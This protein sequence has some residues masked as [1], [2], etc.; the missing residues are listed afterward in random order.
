M[1][2]PQY[3]DQIEVEA[4]V[5]DAMASCVT[6]SA[7]NGYGIDFL[8]LD[9]SWYSVENDS[10]IWTIAVFQNDNKCKKT[11]I[12]SLKILLLKG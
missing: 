12:F 11:I 9:K 10:A 3:P 7:I 1:L 2:R 5:A 6:K 8:R 4:K